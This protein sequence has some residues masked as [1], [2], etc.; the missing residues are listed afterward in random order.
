MAVKNIEMQKKNA[1]GSFDIF[2]PKTKASMVIAEDGSNLE[3]HLA[4]NV[5]H[6]TSTERTNWNGKQS[7]LPVENRRKITFGTANPSGG[8]NGDIYFQYE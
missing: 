8:V 5:Q 7:A 3:S 4:D 6:I 1:D 2:H